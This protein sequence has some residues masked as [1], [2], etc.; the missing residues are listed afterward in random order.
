[1]DCRTSPT[2]PRPRRLPR[3]SHPLPQPSVIRVRR[4]TGEARRP[5][6]L[7]RRPSVSLCRRGTHALCRAPRSRQRCPNPARTHE[8]LALTPGTA[9]QVSDSGS[10]PSGHLLPTSPKA[11][12]TSEPLRCKS[13]TVGRPTQ[14]ASTHPAHA[15]RND[16]SHGSAHAAARMNQRGPL[17]PT[18]TSFSTDFTQSKRSSEPGKSRRSTAT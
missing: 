3:L 15:S 14:L 16:P 11:V 2:H 6:E 7:R 4:R 9:R 5:R 1:M 12:R 18:R 13:P 10:N 17:A 8:P